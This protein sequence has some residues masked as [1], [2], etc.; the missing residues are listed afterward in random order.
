MN[1][2]ERFPKAGFLSEPFGGNEIIGRAKVK[3]SNSIPMIEQEKV[4]LDAGS[5]T[6]RRFLKW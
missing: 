3:I 5:K 1:L 2:L 6:R 4:Q